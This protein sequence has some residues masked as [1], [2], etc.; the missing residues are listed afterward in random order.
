MTVIATVLPDISIGDGVTTV[1]Q[2]NFEITATEDLDVFLDDVLQPLSVAYTVNGVGSET[3]G[4][5]T[6]VTAPAN[7]VQVLR[8]LGLTYSQPTSYSLNGPFPS[9][10]HEDALDRLALLLAQLREEV[11]RGPKFKPAIEALY[12]D[13]LFPEA[14]PLHLVGWDATGAKLA[15]F[16][17][18][19]LTVTP[20]PGG[21]AVV[22][23]QA[24][25]AVNASN[26]VIQLTTS[27]LVPAG[28]RLTD[29]MAFLATAWSTETRRRA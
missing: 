3:G 28:A 22:T 13:L 21:G 7:G 10:S 23:A 8:T 1:F 19:I 26:G 27:G 9:L 5:I 17:S 11:G 16:P 25:Q 2:Y 6:F 4:N 18:T 20:L 15:L 14:I 24:T 29:G 12:R